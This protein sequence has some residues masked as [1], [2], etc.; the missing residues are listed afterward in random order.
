MH[1]EQGMTE[2]EIQRFIEMQSEEG[3]TAYEAISALLRLVG[4]DHVP[5]F[6]EGKEGEGATIKRLSE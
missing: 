3:K 4:A 5:A 6:R 1:E 2:K